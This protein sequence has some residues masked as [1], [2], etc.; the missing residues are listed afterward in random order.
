LSKRSF[1][2]NLSANLCLLALLLV[3]FAISGCAAS[4]TSSVSQEETVDAPN[5]AVQ[6]K[7]D[8]TPLLSDLRS[9]S[10]DSFEGRK[11]GT[12]GNQKARDYIVQAFQKHGLQPY[13]DSLIQRHSWP[14]RQMVRTVIFEYIER[15]Y[16]TRRRHS[17]LG[18]LSPSEYEEVKLRGGAVA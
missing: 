6:Q 5:E 8:A 10:D 15:F 3:L 1:F 2:K 11:T 9:L 14:N 12:A 13:D 17:A 7:V 16:N 4:E 18:N